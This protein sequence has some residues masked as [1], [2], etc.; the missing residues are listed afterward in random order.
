[1]ANAG[2]AAGLVAAIEIAMASKGFGSG[3]F[4]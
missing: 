1:M 3:S 2:L 4:N